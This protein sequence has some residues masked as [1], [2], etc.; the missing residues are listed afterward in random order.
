MYFVFVLPIIKGLYFLLLMLQ[1]EHYNSF[2]LVRYFKKYYFGLPFVVCCYLTGLFFFKNSYIDLFVYIFVFVFSL[3]KIKYIVKLKFTKRICRLSVLSVLLCLIPFLFSF[4]RVTFILII[5]VLPFI[6]FFSSLLICPLE[7]LIKNYYKKKV[8]RRLEKIN[9]YVVCITGSFGKTSVKRMLEELYK[10]E[11]FV[12]ATPKSYN[13]PMG[14]ARCVL[15]NMSGLSEIFFCEAGATKKGDINEIVNMVKPDVGVITSIGYQHMSSFKS[16]D[17]VLKTKLE[18]V[19]GLGCDGKLVLNYGN[20][21]LNGIEVDGVKECIGVNKRYGKYYACNIKYDDVYTEFDIYSYN[22]FILHIK[23]KL[24]GDHNIDNI[25]L[26]YGVKK[27]LDDKFYLSDES[28]KSGVLKLCNVENRLSL[29]SDVDGSNFRFLDDSFN[30]NTEGFVSA[31]NVLKRLNGIKCIIT[32]G[33]VDGGSYS[34]YINEKLS[35]VLNGLDDIVFVNNKEVKKL[36]MLLNK[37]N[38]RYKCVDSYSEGVKY[39]KDK[40]SSFSDVFV[41]VLVENDLPDNYLM[42]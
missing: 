26:C 7:I 35:A 16:I 8:A 32:P 31:V 33:V 25:V 2:S 11:Y 20:E 3:I 17:N 21:Y 1:Q 4:N 18:L 19:S 36:K 29:K 13:T 38:I 22:K 12:Y 39:L 10:S 42:R 14:I 30:S 37:R 23:T 24:L 28:F 6:V 40:Y 5:F 27:M 15:N 41:N 9:P 34:N